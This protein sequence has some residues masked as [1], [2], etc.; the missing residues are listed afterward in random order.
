MDKV[1]T[2]A[3]SA[4]L[5]SL[6]AAKQ[7]ISQNPGFNYYSMGSKVSFESIKSNLISKDFDM[8][9]IPLS[10]AGFSLPDGLVMA[11]VSQ[12]SDS[13]LKFIGNFECLDG[14]TLRD[15][16]TGSQ[17]L[18][19]NKIIADQLL[20]LLPDIKV[21]VKKV[22]ASD[23]HKMLL[24]KEIDGYVMPDFLIQLEKVD[25]EK[26]YCW[27]FSPYEV[28]SKAGSGVVTYLCRMDD[29]ILRRF[30]KSFHDGSTSRC[31]NIERKVA[32]VFPNEEIAAYCYIDERNNFQIHA[33]LT[34][35]VNDRCFFTQSTS[36]NLAEKIIE[37]LK[38]ETNVSHI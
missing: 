7:I 2:I 21:K 29:I 1:L 18:V 35:E 11:G 25:I 15:I 4:D 37:I 36:D 17:V 22:K 3:S 30:I 6:N 8:A 5:F 10:M 12:R 26:F 28:I 19:A 14:S 23:A 31:T 13:T 16:K 9:C 34:K 38:N 20:V 27:T 33:S 32:K 24:N